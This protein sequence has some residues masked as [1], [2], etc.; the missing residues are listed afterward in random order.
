VFFSERL[1]RDHDLSG[2]PSGKEAL[3][4]WLKKHAL[5][6]DRSGT[7]RTYVWIDEAG[8]LVAYFTLAPHLVRREQL[9]AGVARGSPDAIPS[10]LLARLALDRSLHGQGRGAVLLADALMV[11]LEAMRKVGGRLIVVD[12]IDPHAAAFYEH[13]GFTPV[14]GN[15]HRLVIKASSA[16][17]SFSVPWP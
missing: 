7:G 12:A 11:A 6:A 14:P 1:H 10:I 15:P 9:P 13:H 8:Q 16:A 5:H 2:F 17:K 3:D 4:V